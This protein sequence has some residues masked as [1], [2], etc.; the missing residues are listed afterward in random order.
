[1][2]EAPFKESS[3]IHCPE[4]LPTV[5]LGRDLTKHLK[6]GHRWAFANAFDESIKFKSGLTYLRYKDEI[7]GLGLWQADTQLRFRVFCLA[8][9]PFYRKNNPQKTL[10]FWAEHQ[11]KKA[12]QV[13]MAVDL[14]TTN[15]FRLINGEGDGMPGLVIDIY[16]NTAVIKHDH[17]VLE[18]LWNHQELARRI[19]KSFPDITCVYLKRRNDDAIKGEN[20]LGTLAEETIFRENGLLFSSNIRD[21]AKTGFFLD[22]R[23]NRR[24]LQ[25][26]SKNK[27]VLNLFSYT[28][29]FSVFAAAGGARSVTSV[30]IAK[31][32]IQA[33]QRN[34]ELN[35]LSTPITNIATDAFA[36]VEEQIRAKTK[37]DLVITDPPSFAPNEKSVP[38]ATA[39][40]IRIFADSLRLVRDEGLFA[41]SSCSSHISTEAFFEITREAFSKARRRGTLLHVGAQPFDHPFPLA[42]EELRYL[43]FALFRLD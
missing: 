24:Y 14:K 38:Q 19:Q 15:S 40:Y 20:I 7:L 22:Q 25:Q 27:D 39:A 30:D 10:E 16:G 11:W 4:K 5:A 37:F 12:L 31:V 41:A 42:M 8:D 18:S 26:F 1:M 23:D 33:V 35:G 43:K 34:F 2:S 13:R 17:A 29:G 6:R 9:E 3:L 28:G 32:A 21:A 36:Y